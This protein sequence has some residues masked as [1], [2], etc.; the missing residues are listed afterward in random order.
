MNS[1]KDLNPFA[2][3]K[4]KQE[5]EKVWKSLRAISKPVSKE[6]A[7]RLILEAVRLQKNER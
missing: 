4:T 5:R 3:A 1:K 6:E 7:E 2:N